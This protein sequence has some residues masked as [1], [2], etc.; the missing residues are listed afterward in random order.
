MSFTAKSLLFAA[1]LILLHAAYSTYEHMSQ[2]KALG[3]PEDRL[4]LDIIIESIL[5]L[6]TGIIGATLN[7]AELKEIT[8]AS[9]MKNR[10][11]DE[12]DSRL[13]FANFNNKGKI[14]FASSNPQS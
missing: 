10:N 13:G 1:S 2:L 4:P 9:E 6:A 12:M 5:A 7:S 3:R 8:W 14:F 11:I